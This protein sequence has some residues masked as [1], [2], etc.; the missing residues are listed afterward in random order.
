MDTFEG[1]LLIA[2]PQLGDDN[3]A[4]AVVLLIQHNE[5]GAF[6]VVINNPIQKTLQELWREVGSAPCHSRQPVYLGGPVPGPLMSLHTNAEMAESEPVPGV[7]FAARKQHLD[8]LVLS[9]EPGYKVFI[10]HAGWGAGQLETELRQGAWRTMPATA[11][12]I[13]S[14]ADDLWETVFRQFGQSVVQS[15]LHLKELPADPTVN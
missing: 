3:F 1:Q 6:G 11:E 10:Q 12:I 9:D 7:F 4:R 8:Q 5:D 14:A 2:S 15:V 13:F